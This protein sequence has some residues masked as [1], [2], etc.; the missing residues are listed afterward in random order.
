MVTR[1]STTSTTNNEIAARYRRCW[2]PPPLSLRWPVAAPSYPVLFCGG[3]QLQQGNKA[4]M[5]KIPML[6]RTNGVRLFR[7]PNEQMAIEY[8]K[9]EPHVGGMAFDSAL[10][11][12]A[13]T[14]TIRPKRPDLDRIVADA[15][16]KALAYDVLPRAGVPPIEDDADNDDTGAAMAKV[17][18]FL[19]NIV[20]PDDLEIVQALLCGAADVEEAREQQALARRELDRRTPRQAADQARR[21]P[22]SGAT[23]DAYLQLF[24]NANR[25]A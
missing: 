7:L 17:L 9:G 19:E 3:Q 18:E 14:V 8:Q 22:M 4:M 1:V 15:K 10:G 16:R 11:S 5:Y 2:V 13:R 20:S 25:L 24:P 23:E 21:R 6:T 12:M